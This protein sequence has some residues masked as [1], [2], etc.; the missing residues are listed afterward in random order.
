MPLIPDAPP[1]AYYPSA[2]K[3]GYIDALL[4]RP[5]MPPNNRIRRDYGEE[6]AQRCATNYNN[7]YQAGTNERTHQQEN[8]QS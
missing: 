8:P 4:G 5:P 3:C 2:W 6:A 1:T 7:G